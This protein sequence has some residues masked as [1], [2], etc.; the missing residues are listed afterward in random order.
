MESNI[1]ILA[2][3]SY[4]LGSIPF[5]F[6]VPK[7]FGIGDIRKV[8]SGNVGATN[9]LR[10]GKKSLAFLVLILDSLKGFLPVFLITNLYINN[11][12][13]FFI[14]IFISSFAIL[15]HIFPIWLKFQGGKGVA[16]YIGFIFSIDYLLGLI[17][18]IIWLLIATLSRYSSLSSIVSL[19]LMPFILFI[20]SYQ[21]NDILLFIA[22]SIII[23]L[24]HYSNI[25]RL[26]S[27]KETKISF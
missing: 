16:T 6:I 26:I 23:I 21:S 11:F 15:G 4:F 2:I 27:K 5:A 7:I 25:K 12:E 18:L 20:F 19:I 17:F 10:T 22:I 14:I 24:K 3:I 8:G 9:V 13:Y 1:I